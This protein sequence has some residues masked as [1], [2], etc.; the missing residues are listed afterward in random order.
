MLPYFFGNK[1]HDRMQQVDNPTQDPSRGGL[2]LGPSRRVLALQDGLSEL[3]I[4]V[5][6]GAPYEMVQAARRL[7]ETI[8][9]ESGRSR[10]GAVRGRCSDPAVDGEPAIR[11]SEFGNE[12]APVHLRIT[13][14]VPQL[15]RK[16]PVTLDP[17]FGELDIAA[18]R[19]QRRQGEAQSIAALEVDQLQR[20]D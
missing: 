14:R 9:I 7:V 8:G 2:G 12:R 17:A 3:D 6:E 4:P 20:V 1:G 10:D 13:C 15:G 19:R 5:A 16:I 11:W 18:G